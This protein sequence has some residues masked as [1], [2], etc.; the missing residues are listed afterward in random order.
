M[1]LTHCLQD[2]VEATRKSFA[3]GLG[4]WDLQAVE[5]GHP[6]FKE[7]LLKVGANILAASMRLH[8]LCAACVGL[9]LH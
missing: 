3:A 7:R 6:E 1:A 8:A 5:S 9:I 2:L 4:E